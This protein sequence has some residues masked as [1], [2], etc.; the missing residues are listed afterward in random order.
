LPS[1]AVIDSATFLNK[2]EKMK[3]ILDSFT[4]LDLQPKYLAIGK[5]NA[6][7]QGIS[8]DQPTRNLESR[9]VSTV[10]GLESS[11]AHTIE[12]NPK[13]QKIAQKSK[14]KS[15]KRSRSPQYVSRS[16]M[17]NKTYLLRKEKN[18]NFVESLALK[19]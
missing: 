14:S 9:P 5:R 18:I 11:K 15:K 7:L 2:I 16:F 17:V 8:T 13:K 12:Q 19:K 3:K 1:L 10:T 4:H 6:S